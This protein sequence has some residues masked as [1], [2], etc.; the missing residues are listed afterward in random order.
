MKVHRP[1]T[2]ALLAY[3]EGVLS[4]KG[5]ARVERHLSRCEVCR[6][7]LCAIRAYDELADAA[8]EAPMPAVDFAKMELA[9]ASEARRI[10]G[11][12]A[13]VERRRPW[14]ALGV[15]A[16]AAALAL[17]FFEW[18]AEPTVA[19]AP[20]GG[21][22]APAADLAEPG[23]SE[24]PALAAEPL[25]PVVTLAA[26][27][28][29]AL[30]GARARA[31]E[32]GGT[33]EEGDR[34]RTG[35]DGVVHVRLASGTAFVAE[36]STELSLARAREDAVELALEHGRVASAVAPL[37]H[38]SRY[39]ILSAGHEV[40][41]RGTRFAVS[42]L[43][44]VVGVDLA[45]GRVEVRTPA[46][47]VIELD[48]PARWRS[49]GE[50]GGGPEDV[51]APRELIEAAE[52]TLARLAHPEIVRWEIDGTSVAS[53]GEL[54]LRLGQGE[55]ELRGWDLRGRL[56]TARLPVGGAP[57]FLEPG[58]LTAERPRLRPGHLEQTQIAPV[59]Q[60]ARPQLARCYERAL[61]LHP[62]VHGRVR[63]RVTVGLMG[64]VTRVSVLGADAAD[65][66]ELR[67]CVATYAERWTFPPPGGPVTF[68]VPLS[69]SARLP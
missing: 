7:E 56:F 69:F 6:R 45:E 22:A 44:G 4:A 34:V 27:T 46:G 68:E 66:S 25:S 12:I 40:E 17:A 5:R 14:L 50:A 53:G 18:P 37:A 11:Q 60:R 30:T 61:R 24:A 15:V 57:V 3:A 21:G 67:D 29:E 52:L 62:E 42:H 1:K 59:L 58:A 41:V 32:P 36:R 2:A 35:E 23:G 26:G 31:L 33:L 20:A 10:S 55:H 19:A 51:P 48:A 49:S 47:E 39:V 8:R 64:D 63:L 43:E 38:G 28:T 16:A 9:L 54:R 65:T 13:T